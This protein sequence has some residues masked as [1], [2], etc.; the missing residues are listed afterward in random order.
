MEARLDRA[1]RYV[2]YFRDPVDAELFLV[3]QRDDCPLLDAQLIERCSQLLDIVLR[4]HRGIRRP[5]PLL[6]RQLLQSLSKYSS[7]AIE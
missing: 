7:Y 4:W 5:Q 1:D 6:F 2:E 3:V